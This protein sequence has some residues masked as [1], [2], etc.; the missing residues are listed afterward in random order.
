[1]ASFGAERC[2]F[3]Q[4]RGQV[5]C[6]WQ[7]RGDEGDTEAA[8]TEGPGEEAAEWRCVS[9]VEPAGRAGWLDVGGEGG[10]ASG[11]SQAWGLGQWMVP[12]T[13]VRTTRVHGRNRRLKAKAVLRHLFSVIRA[14]P[15]PPEDRLHLARLRVSTARR[16][17]AFAWRLLLLA[18]GGG[19]WQHGIQHPLF[20]F[21]G[22]YTFDERE[23]RWQRCG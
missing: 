19:F 5:R 1:M 6:G 10:G 11:D 13:R 8:D 22:L 9:G 15:N 3:V 7:F 14:F 23:Q 20:F 12:P 4:V 16:E 18:R 17:V 2:H 21:F